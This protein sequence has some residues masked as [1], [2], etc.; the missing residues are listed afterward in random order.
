MLERSTTHRVTPTRG[1]A[2]V[3]HLQYFLYRQP[4]YQNTPNYK[5]LTHTIMAI[6]T[7]SHGC[8]APSPHD[9]SGFSWLISHARHQHQCR[10]SHSIDNLSCKV[11]AGPMPTPKCRINLCL[12][13]S[14][15]HLC[16][17]AFKLVG[18]PG[19][20]ISSCPNSYVVY[21]TVNYICPWLVP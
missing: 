3:L 21:E 15:S 6:Q 7:I 10:P 5:Q 8:I 16:M 18:L 20:P 14:L 9:F 11:L 2:V 1:I 17:Y 4:S 12:P 19:D 13:Y